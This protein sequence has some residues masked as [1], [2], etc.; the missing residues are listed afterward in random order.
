M[1]VCIPFCRNIFDSDDY[2]PLEVLTDE[3]YQG[4]LETFPYHNKEL[5]QAQFPKRFPFS[6]MVHQIY[7]QLKQFVIKCN[8]YSLKLN[9]R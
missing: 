2:S 8:S 7:E 9:M 1:F 4:V 3:R 5:A 6:S